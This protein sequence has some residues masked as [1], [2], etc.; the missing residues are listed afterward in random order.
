MTSPHSIVVLGVGNTLM[1]DDGIG[2]AAVR[3]LA[4]QYRFPPSVRLIEAGVAGLGLLPFIREATHLLIIDAVRA[5]LAPGA[6]LRLT[7][8][9]LPKHRGLLLS[10]HEVGI[11][12]V[13]EMA[14]FVGRLPETRIIGVQPLETDTVGLEVTPQLNEALP[15]VLMAAVEELRALGVEVSDHA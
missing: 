11:T 6:I 9:D 5:G 7:P 4:E 14:R 3:A 12:E 1:K 10:A 8:D 2:V 15:Q 13:I